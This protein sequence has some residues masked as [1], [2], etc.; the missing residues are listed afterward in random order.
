MTQKCSNPRSSENRLTIFEEMCMSKGTPTLYTLGKLPKIRLRKKN[1]R[2]AKYKSA[3]WGI[4]P[5][6]GRPD[7]QTL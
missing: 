5:Q 1:S 4:H 6:N 2:V 7:P 3:V